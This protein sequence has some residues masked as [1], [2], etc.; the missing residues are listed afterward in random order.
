MF[1]ES[2]AET[3]SGMTV[4][5]FSSYRYIN[6]FLRMKCAPDLLGALGKSWNAKEITES[7]GAKRAI[8]KT[9]GIESFGNYKIIALD[10]ASGAQSRTGSLLACLTKWGVIAIDPALKKQPKI[11][12]V[13]HFSDKI[14]NFSLNYNYPVVVAAVHAHCKL[15]HI[16]QNVKTPDLTIVAIPCCQPLF[17]TGR[18]PNQEYVDE[19]ILSPKRTIKIWRFR[20]L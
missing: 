20:N 12:R 11:R 6:E 14:E 19:H 17:I 10:V 16:V 2:S 1:I 3:K 15:D 8:K 7:L 18:E 13:S 5:V 9:L 4:R